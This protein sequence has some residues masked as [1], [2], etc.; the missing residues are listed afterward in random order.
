MLA[1]DP[2]TQ[3]AICIHATWTTDLFLTLLWPNA[4]N[5]DTSFDIGTLLRG[6]G[7]FMARRLAV[8]LALLTALPARAQKTLSASQAKDHIGEQATVCGKIV[9]TRYAD[10]THGS[11]TF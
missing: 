4:E 6:K 2:S 7:G 5:G 8:L 9:S 1:W 10:T 11:P 3:F